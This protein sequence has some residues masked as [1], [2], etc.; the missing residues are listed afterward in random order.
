MDFKLMLSNIAK[1]LVDEPADVNVVEEIDGDDVQ[2]TL[3]VAE[4]DM[5]MVLGRH[6]K[7]AKAIRSVMKAAGNKYGKRITVEIR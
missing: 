5:G 4:G 3:S 7:I 2:L 1:A 6:G